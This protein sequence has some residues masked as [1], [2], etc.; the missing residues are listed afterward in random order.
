MPE[1]SR[2]HSF[3]FGA[4]L[5]GQAHR[6]DAAPK[7]AAAPI[8]VVVMSIC[9]NQLFGLVSPTRHVKQQEHLTTLPVPNSFQNLLGQFTHPIPAGFTDQRVWIVALTLAVVASLETLLALEASDRLD[10]FK[11]I[12]PPNRELVA[13][14][15]GNTD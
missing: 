8:I 12:S 1:Q 14:G 2:F 3:A 15:V 5:L 11:R 7:T 6:Q 4:D 9:I 10:P 13:Q